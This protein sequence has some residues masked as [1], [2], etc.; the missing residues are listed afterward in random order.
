[1]QQRRGQLWRVLQRISLGKANS[2]AL[3]RAQDGSL[4]S[5]PKDQAKALAQHWAGVFSAKPSDE[6]KIKQWP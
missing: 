5:E 6:D 4:L 3:V 1:M 2:L